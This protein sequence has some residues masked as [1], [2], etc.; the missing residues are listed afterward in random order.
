MKVSSFS[1]HIISIRL[2]CLK[3]MMWEEIRSSYIKKILINLSVDWPGAYV[4]QFVTFLNYFSKFRAL[5]LTTR[6]C[7]QFPSICYQIMLD[8]LDLWP[9]GL[10][11][12]SFI[13]VMS[14]TPHTMIISAT[15]RLIN[16]PLDHLKCQTSYN[17]RSLSCCTPFRCLWVMTVRNLKGMVSHAE[18]LVCNAQYASVN[19]RIQNPN[20]RAFYCVA[21]IQYLWLSK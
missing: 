21:T 4:W 18:T 15:E 17:M 9:F 7:H 6:S 11:C 16:G 14:L 10:F 12:I 8:F 3:L 2:N 19:V 1:L 13:Y 20:V 5:C